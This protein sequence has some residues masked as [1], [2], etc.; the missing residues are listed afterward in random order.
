MSGRR[1]YIG[2]TS[3]GRLVCSRWNRGRASSTRDA[4]DGAAWA[5]PP[6][7]GQMRS[8]REAWRSTPSPQISTSSRLAS[9]SAASRSGRITA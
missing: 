2:V 8:N 9:S 7:S 1:R 6:S 4:A 5:G 3:S